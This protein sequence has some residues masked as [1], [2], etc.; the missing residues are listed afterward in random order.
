MLDVACVSPRSAL[1]PWILLASVVVLASPV[2]CQAAPPTNGQPQYTPDANAPR[3]AIPALF[4]W[5]LTPLFASDQAWERGRAKLLSEVPDLDAFEGKLGDPA[6]LLACLDLYFALHQEANF[7]T[8]YA[9]LRQSTEQSSDSAATMVQK[10][11]S[12]MDELMRQAAFIRRDLL[13]MPQ[14]S[15]E[16]AYSAQPRLAGYR[17]YIENLRR[18]ARRILSPDAERALSLLGDNL[19]AEVDLNEIPSPHEDVFSALLADIEWPKV[20]DEHGQP[21]QLT[22]ANYPVFRQSPDRDVRRHAVE[23]FLGTLRKYQHTLAGTLAGQVKLDV[24][25]AR[26][27]GYDT[28]LD[29]YLDK[30]GL[31]PAIY[32]NLIATVNANLPL[33]HRYIGLRKKVLDLD[34]VHLYDLYVPLL[35]GAASNIPFEQAR[36]VILEA[37]KPLGADYEKALAGGLDPANGWLDLYPHT[38]KESGAFSS[39]VY[40]RHP[41]VFTNYQCSLYDVSTLAHE[42]GHAMHSYLAAKAQPYPTFRY[43]P[44]LAEI[45]STC[46]EA[47]LS[48]YLIGRTSDKAQKADLLVARLESIRTTIL[49]QTMFAQFEREIHQLQE[50]GTPLTATVLEQKYSGLLKTYYGP[51]YAIGPDDGLEW[52]YIAHFYYKYYVY[53]YATGMASGIAIAERVRELGP[54]AAEAYLGMLKGGCAEPP[55]E[56]LRKAGVDLTTPAAIEASMRAFGQT[57]DELEKLLAK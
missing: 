32:D 45:A 44:F 47:L 21:V 40:G 7:V 12:A 13:T 50:A 33:L 4:K 34:E 22:L 10:S 25:Y 53:S 15:L 35:P 18:R 26:A 6:R 46:N 49:R 37:L 29:A 17:A 2:I 43:T 8:L 54:P 27:R 20:R 30:D 41:Y 51:A 42:Y 1:L 56:L 9:N 16:S 14:A 5:D 38:D 31:T 23:A 28:A 57:L 11:L 48:D 52:G 19:W 24:A 55:L 36:G 39:S 3:S